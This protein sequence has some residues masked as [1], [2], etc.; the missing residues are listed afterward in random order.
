MLEL[1]TIGGGEYIVNVM[2]AVAAWTGGGG[3]KSLIRVVLV[4]GLIYTLLIVAFNLDW[5]A[6]MN[7]FLQSTL[8]YLCL[9]VP[10][11]TVK[12]TDR[13]N[14]G[15]APS[16]VA[17]V[18]LGLGL[19][20]SFTSQVGDYLTREA[21][22]VFVMPAQ[23]Q[24]SSNGMIYGSR[25]MEETR[26]IRINDPEFAANINEHMKRCVFYDVMMGFKSMDSLARSPDLWAD[27]GPGSPARFQTFLTRN[28]N[29]PGA[30]TATAV[31][32]CRDAYAA[33]TPQW[34]Q[35][36]T[37]FNLPWAKHLYPNYAN[38][39]A[40]AK[41]AA[42]LP[43]TY[44]AFTGNAANAFAIMRQ[45]LAI[46]AFM[47]ARDDMS[48][49]TG[50]SSI[51]SFAATRADLQ[52]RNTYSAIAQGAM[53]WVP[54]LNIVL[55]VVF[56]AMFPVLF[57][58]FLI[59]RTGVGALK[60]YATGFFYLAA[61]GPLY[62]V[63][64]MILLS[65]GLSSGNAIAAGGMSLGSFAGIGAINDETATLAGYMIATVPF[66][67]AGMARGAMAI[68]GQAT[69]F[70]APSQNAAEAAAL[71]ATTGNYA[72]GNASLANATVNTQSR[73]QW[74]A[75]PN[76]ASGAPAFSFRQPNGTISTLNAD[77]SVV[78]NQQPA[79]SSFE[80]KPSFTKGNLGELRETV[81][82]FQNQS[83]QA[84]EHASEAWSAA[85]TLGSQIF[86]TV[87]ASRGSE[88]TT[89][90]QLQDSITESQNLTR[91]WSD[92]LVNDYGFDR[93]SA[94]ELARYSYLQGSADLGVGVPIPGITAGINASVLSQESRNRLSGASV[95]E[96]ISKGLDFLNSESTS[97]NA[98]R[99]RESF[100]R[101][102]STSGNSELEGLTRRRDASVTQ[103]E[104][105]TREA[106]RLEEVG[107]RYDRQISDIESGGFQTSRDYSQNWQSFVASEMARNPSLRDSGYATWMRDVDLDG[108]RPIGPQRDARDVLENRF[109]RS[110]VDDMRREL[111]PIDPLAS[112]GIAAPSVA[113]AA[114]VQAWGHRQV[115]DVNG[116]GPDVIVLRDS[117]DTS[118]SALVGD[119]ISGAN[120]RMDGRQRD[121]NL[122]N[123][124]IH[125]Q[126][127][128]L[129]GDVGAAQD[130]PLGRTMPFVAPILDRMNATHFDATN[131][132][133]ANGVGVKPGVT[134]TSLD[135]HM[136]MPIA[137]VATE[138]RALGLTAPT[139]TSGTDGH[140]MDGSLHPDGDA[141]DFR[142]NNLT[143]TQ[144]RALQDRVR[145]ALGRDYDVKFE[146]FR[147][148]SRNHLHIEYDPKPTGLR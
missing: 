47:Q 133:R 122:S 82:Q 6:W 12:V 144:G 97:D 137:S 91:S 115:G 110:F 16:V 72:Y 33:L 102:A 2:N 3:Y 106:G 18:P 1:F 62:V 31:I 71:E 147:D 25:L 94:D 20:A 28:G 46:N 127:D 124:Y 84:R 92:R 128:A 39:V 56:Y 52:T 60:G 53:K 30:T 145:N 117:R 105:F 138:S 85:N 95:N 61:W 22:T 120:D 142:G 66:L 148:P 103:A 59:P 121:T 76:F 119:R 13:V 26:Q 78:T 90:R 69:S 15:L 74:N 83:T 38:A 35:F 99:S 123:G 81:G 87:Q 108:G 7:W 21:E 36:L 64:H 104:T 86:K 132:I 55:T 34:Q 37:G 27:I 40:Q 9:M 79:I 93:R 113:N 125:R 58:L 107:K 32:S 41:L 98:I 8:I 10:T 67:A 43:V 5:R 45:S 54:I 73:D 112:S 65:K 100:F 48:G 17:N 23:L 130:L 14:A 111:G 129:S 88:T 19:I 139:I 51:D 63:L 131:Y 68:A 42:D 75:Q 114:D 24:Y 141:L 140:H 146:T 57:P 29:G 4:M 50:A 109:R 143:I 116:S 134:V 96:R 136:Q 101:A 70:L 11:V 49:G 77:G 135:K 80:W 89:G 118:L 44:Q 126:G